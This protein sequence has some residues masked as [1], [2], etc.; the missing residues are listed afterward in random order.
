MVLSCWHNHL[1]CCIMI[2][3]VYADDWPFMQGDCAGNYTVLQ[4]VQ[5][6]FGTT[7]LQ[8][9]EEVE[10][11]LVGMGAKELPEDLVSC[12]PQLSHDEMVRLRA[13]VSSVS[14]PALQS[15]S[16]PAAQ[17]HGSPAMHV[18]SPPVAQ[19]PGPSAPLNPGPSIQVSS[20][21]ASPSNSNATRY[22]HELVVPE[23]FCLSAFCHLGA[24]WHEAS[25]S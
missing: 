5:P 11:L 6:V 22:L 7:A 2:C 17:P 15:S 1:A 3:R 24:Y 18:S 23:C 16:P 9:Q 21:T 4:G 14:S 10:S 25:S 13:L 12:I 19:P 8:S 20:P